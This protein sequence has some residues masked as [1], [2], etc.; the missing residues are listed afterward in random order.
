MKN[1]PSQIILKKVFKKGRPEKIL[2]PKGFLK[3]LEAERPFGYKDGLFWGCAVSA[4][5]L[6]WISIKRP[7]S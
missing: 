4:R 6:P 3:K 7:R 5:I 1:K 2:V